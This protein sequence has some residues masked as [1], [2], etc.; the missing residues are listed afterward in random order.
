VTTLRLARGTLWRTLVDRTNAACAAGALAPIETHEGLVE[1]EG[2]RFSLRRAAS[3]A[4]KPVAAAHAAATPDA[5][6]PFLPPDPDLVVGEITDAHLAALNKFPVIAH[7][8]L[9]ITRD[10]VPQTAP[11][12]RG[13]MLAM[14]A[15]LAEYPALAFY[16][17]GEIAGA[18]QPHKHLQ[19]VPLPLAAA[20][21]LPFER[22]LLPLGR[23]A[24]FRV[25]AFRFA[26]AVG[27]MPRGWAEDLNAAAGEVLALCRSLLEAAE[28]GQGAY[29]L[30]CSAGH[31]LVVARAQ[32][33]FRGVS[34]N[35]LGF[36]G[37]LFARDDRELAVLG[38]TGPL[39]V[40]AAVSR[41]LAARPASP[42]PVH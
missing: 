35:S 13:D 38:A 27:I 7:H 22:G 10:Y 37:S 42:E 11:L 40:L 21:G 23:N 34:V 9:V 12:D 39:D 3:L 8:L 25:S 30:L 32:E 26:H 15:C 17:G 31:M 4:T 28:V 29:N 20:A 16:N 18:S 41:P 33:R 5:R 24:L 36:A 6:N 14:L 1:Q 19:V 2:V